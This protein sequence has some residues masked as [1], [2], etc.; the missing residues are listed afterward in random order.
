[1][2]APC[3]KKA[4]ARAVALALALASSSFS[5]HAVL[6]RTGPIS[7]APNVGGFPAWYQDTTGLALEFCAPKNQAELDGAWCLLLPGDINLLPEVFPSNF[8]DEHF[9]YA[10]GAALGTRQAGG[11]ANLV[12]G[13][14]SAFTTAVAP[15][16]QVVFARIRL[17]L[18]PLPVSGSYRFIHPYGEQTVEGVVGERI[19]VTS[20]IGFDCGPNFECALN[21]AIGP[22]LLPSPVP[23]GVEMPPLTAANPIPDS[24]PNN[25][26]DGVFA[27]TPYPGTGDAYI[28][29]PAREGPVTGSPLPDFVDS[30]GATRNHNIFRI[31]GPPGSGLGLDPVTGAPVDWLETSKFSLMGRIYSGAM[32]GR[33]TVDRASYTRTAAGQKLDVFATALPTTQSRLPAGPRPAA[34]ATNL[35]FF[36]A[37]CAGTVDAAGTIHP[38]YSTPPGATE[39]PMKAAGA[40]QMAQTNPTTIPKSICVKDGSARNAA[41]QLAPVFVPHPVTDEVTVTPAHFDPAAGTLSVGASSSDAT[42]PLVLTLAAGVFLGDL[43]AGEIAV[44]GVIAP[45][46][47]VQVQSSALGSTVYQV[48]TGFGGAAPV[49]TPVAANDVF[50]FPM[51]SPAQVL[52]VLANDSNVA[53]GTVTLLSQPGFGSAAVNADGTVSYTPDPNRS[54]ADAFTYA[55]TVGTSVSNT[56][57]ATLDVVSVPLAP[58]AVNDAFNAIANAPLA[59]NLIANDSDPN[60]AADIVGALNI[61]ASSPAGAAISGGADGTVSFSAATPGTYT[62][63]YQ[64]LDQAGLSSA[65]TGTV[66]V[67]VAAAE[68]ITFS[69]TLFRRD[70]NRLTAN[71]TINPIGFQTIKLEFVNSAGTVLGTAGTIASTVL[72]TWAIDTV[73]PMPTGTVSLKATSSNGTSSATALRIK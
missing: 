70:K 13:M 46:S 12:I 3:R 8:F 35:T 62:F 63:T 67:Q 48:S 7:I 39:M 58:T 72:G 41:G 40:L 26:N 17:V 47:S 24:D 51:N 66:T 4:G 61:S 55:V 54:G 20:D 14:E 45:P 52:P 65:N 15:G 60:G 50:A 38:P 31:E 16:D 53:G 10:A 19:F 43:V 9:Y 59:L 2:F 6:E 49:T 5:A 36:D 29:D 68:T 30:S 22:F 11:K 69:A 32:P 1:M 25:W 34:A 64:A 71:G 44:P 21:G 23:G 73:V 33:V 28:A 37:P 57:I 56:A 18:N 42:P 27:P